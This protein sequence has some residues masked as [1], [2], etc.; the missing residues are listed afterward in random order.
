M[1]DALNTALT[2]DFISQASLASLG[3]RLERSNKDS[4]EYNVGYFR[5]HGNDGHTINST[6]GSLSVEDSNLRRF[7]SEFVYF[8]GST[9][10]ALSYPGA[11]NVVI[12][13]Y[14]K[15]FT[16]SGSTSGGGGNGFLTSN[17]PGITF[18]AAKNALQ[19]DDALY[20]VALV[21]YKT[22]YDLWRATFGGKCPSVESTD[23]PADTSIGS[24]DDDK[25]YEGLDP[26]VIYAWKNGNLE[27][28]LPLDPPPCRFEDQGSYYAKSQM[29]SGDPTLSLEVDSEYPVRY[30]NAGGGTLEAGCMLRVYP[31]DAGANLIPSSGKLLSD[32][33]T[34]NVVVTEIVRFNN[35]ASARLSYQPKN[36][37]ISITPIGGAFIDQYGRTFNPS[38]KKWGETA[39][40]VTWTSKYSY[41][42]PLNRYVDRDELVVT[43][44]VN[45][46]TPCYGA[47]E[48]NYTVEF[49]RQSFEFDYDPLTKTFI[50]ASIVAKSGKESTSIQLNGPSARGYG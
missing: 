49:T 4:D 24:A 41:T 8:S 32:K 39:K 20:G 25:E 36:T 1:A 35:S 5:V 19:S 45:T 12:K 10:A 33:E 23:P 9:T 31:A 17:N 40:S 48:V 30:I 13:P 34:L 38:I 6:S 22:P 27:A 21:E 29:N 2:V 50:P 18:N 26:M 3:I 42:N 37:T 11:Q 43:T 47:A 14:G 7:V 16:D 44:G 46:V 28:S 15:F